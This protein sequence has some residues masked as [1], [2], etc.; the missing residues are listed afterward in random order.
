LDWIT[1]SMKKGAMG[2]LPG[3]RSSNLSGHLGRL[4]GCESTSRRA[5][6][7]SMAAVMDSSPRRAV[8]TERRRTELK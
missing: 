6:A 2:K 4:I 3:D 7:S 1:S 8:A 5:A